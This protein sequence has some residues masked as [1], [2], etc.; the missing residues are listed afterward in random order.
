MKHKHFYRKKL[1]NGFEVL[2]VERRHVP[3]TGVQMVY[4]VGSKDESLSE[5]GLA[6]FMEHMMFKG[7]QNYPLGS[8]DMFSHQCGGDNNAFTSKD[9]TAY[10]FLLPSHS[11]KRCLDLELDRLHKLCLEEDEFDSEKNVVLEEW[12]MCE[13]EPT[14]YMYDQ[15]YQMTFSSEHPYAH[16]VIGTEEA[17]KAMTCEQMKDF[18]KRFYHV[19][20]CSILIIGDVDHQEVFSE[21]E[22]RFGEFELRLAA[23]SPGI[24]AYDLKQRSLVCEKDVECFRLKLS[25]PTNRYDSDWE[26]VSAVVEEIF[27]GGRLSWL[28]QK[29]KEKFQSVTSIGV[30]NDSM[31]YGGLFFIDLELSTDEEVTDILKEIYELFEQMTFD[32][33]SEE[34]LRI[35]KLKVETGHFFEQE[36]LEDILYEISTW[37]YFHRIED[38]FE[39][40]EKVNTVTVE[41]VKRYAKTFFNP[42]L[43]VVSL[44]CPEGELSSQSVDLWEVCNG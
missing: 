13:D 17:L 32:G 3:L 16:P 8:I 26:P 2:V 12:A 30:Y 19:S 36:K 1:S 5:Y 23:T 15:H 35:A 9:C 27:G 11:W 18:Y 41:D 38:Y 25:F 29:V 34:E 43:L 44:M 10:Y 7:S 42:E 39:F 14:E 24:L 4:R 37:M 28:N 6:H 22:K 20:N 21:V 31:H 33:C 40:P